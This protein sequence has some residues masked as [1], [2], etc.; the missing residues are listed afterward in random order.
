MH[1]ERDDA[2]GGELIQSVALSLR[3]MEVLAASHRALGVGELAQLLAMGKSRI[4][5][6]LQ[7]LAA[8]GYVAQDPLT[9]KYMP[10]PAWFFTQMRVTQGPSLSWLAG[11]I[12][13]RLTEDTGL[14]AALVQFENKGARTIY[15]SVASEHIS[16]AIPV[17]TQMPPT[18][19]AFGKVGLAFGSDEWVERHTPAQCVRFTDA[20]ITTVAALN[21]EIEQ[22][23][24][25][26]WATSHGEWVS[27][28]S[29]L[30]APVSW[31]N[32]AAVCAIGVMGPGNVIARAPADSLQQSVLDAAEALQ[33]LWSP[34][35][36]VDEPGAQQP[37]RKRRPPVPI[38]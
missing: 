18:A 2:G 27:G 24:E 31:Q 8:R 6:H 28:I 1:E 13:S 5:R 36:K 29:A 10:G 15:S 25:Q 32:G 33:E 26:G 20:T 17:G 34:D 9:E 21:A 4:F 22:I 23:R 16:I 19:T 7:T 3:V 14:T 12:L 38:R 11:P 30:A 35:Q 37:N